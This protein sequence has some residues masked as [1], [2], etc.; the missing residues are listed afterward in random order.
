MGMVRFARILAAVLLCLLALPGFA[1]A[2]PVDPALTGAGW[3]LL[4][5]DPPPAQFRQLEQGGIEVE[6]K[7]S[8]AVLYRSAGKAEADKPVLSWRWRVDRSDIEPVDLGRK[9]RADRPIALH[10]GF[11]QDESTSDFMRSLA[12]R[13]MGAPPPGRV[14]TYTWGGI[15]KAGEVLVSPYLGDEGRIVILRAGNA[16][17][18]DWV[19]E[20]VDLKADFR[21]FFGYAPPPVAYIA[22]SA[23]ADDQPGHTLARI[24]DISF[25]GAQ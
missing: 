23:D 9:E 17:L 25:Q 22:I 18:R 11:E 6:A 13:M 16:P 14:I 5:F 20:S 21:R 1:S 19:T 24:A 12:A 7:G 8:V 2:Q 10:V 15:Q 4:T 3:K